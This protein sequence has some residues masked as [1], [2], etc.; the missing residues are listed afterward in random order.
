MDFMGS[1]L[2]LIRMRYGEN[3]SIKTIINEELLNY[4]LPPLTIQTLV[5]NAIKHNEISKKNHLRIHILTTENE[6]LI[7]VNDIHKKLTG[8][9]GT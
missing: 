5:E 8:E 7:I 1:Y 9:E 3:L 6:S 4:S 2:F